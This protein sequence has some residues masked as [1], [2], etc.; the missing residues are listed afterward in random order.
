M[1]TPVVLCLL[2]CAEFV[3]RVVLEIRERRATQLHGGLFTLFR[4]VPLLNDLFPLPENRRSPAETLFAKKHEEGHAKEHH[5][6]LRNLLKLAFAMVAIWFLATL[7]VRYAMPFWQAVLWLHLAA[8]PF[9][10]FFHFYCWGQEYEADRFACEK[11]D[12]KV[13]RAALRE[14][15]ECEIPYTPLFALVYREHPTAV[16]RGRRLLNKNVGPRGK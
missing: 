1:F 9:R 3:A 5:S 13:A 12:K 11:T 10:I 4:I 15:A 14:L 6:V 7:L 8:V 2:L 16:L